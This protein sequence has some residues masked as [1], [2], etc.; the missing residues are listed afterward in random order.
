[1]K[2]ILFH[3][4]TPSREVCTTEGSR[5]P[6]SEREGAVQSWCVAHTP[7][8]SGASL[9]G[10]GWGA[11]RRQGREGCKSNLPPTP[12]WRVCPP[13]CS[14]K[15][16]PPSARLSL[17]VSIK[18]PR[19]TENAECLPM[20][21]VRRGRFG[22]SIKGHVFSQP[23]LGRRQAPGTQQRQRLKGPTERPAR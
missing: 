13:H 3:R 16:R 1:M 8:T 4:L 10:C 7:L 11:S 23:E 5:F 21:E 9:G 2:N 14:S 22:S 19:E 18:L 15:T 17:C 6:L 12:P 20:S